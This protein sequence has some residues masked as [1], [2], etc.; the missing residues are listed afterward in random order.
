[1]DTDDVGQRLDSLAA[2]YRRTEKRLKEIRDEL[3]E[4]IVE[5]L[6]AGMKPSE[7]ERRTP[8][9]REHVRRIARQH[10]IERTR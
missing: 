7:V 9:Q 10:G 5:A 6:R 8:Y 3:G 4:T 1:M 2:S